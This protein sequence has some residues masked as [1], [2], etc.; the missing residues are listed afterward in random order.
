MAKL[1]KNQSEVND[2][3]QKLKSKRGGPVDVIVQQKVL[4]PPEHILGGQNRQR[5]TYNQITMPQFVQGFV[6]NIL[7]ES[8][9]QYRE[10]MLQYLGDIMEDASDFSWQ[11]AKASHAVLLCEMERGKVTWTDTTRIDRVRRAYAQKHH[12][13]GRQN[14]GSKIGEI[15]PWFRK[16][17]QSGTCTFDK[18]HE[19][20]G[21][22]H[23]HICAHCLLQGKNLI[24]QN[25]TATL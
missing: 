6:K 7:D 23:R 3:S 14:R 24:T 11:S 9:L 18:D 17:Y 15:K 20:G 25:V 21:R 12:N 5:L 10:H 19:T 2:S 22:T 1:T 8:N 13:N 4:W 16:Q